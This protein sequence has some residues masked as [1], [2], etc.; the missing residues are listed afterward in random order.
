MVEKEDK[1]VL[2]REYIINLRNKVIYTPRYKRTPKA[3]KEL[4]KFVARHM[5]V[6]DNDLRKI[7]LDKYLN[8][9]LWFRGIQKPALKIKI[10]AKK[11]DSGK[12]LVELAELPEILKFKKLREEKIKEKAEKK[13][14]EKEEKKPEEETKQEE[15]AEEKPTEE[16]VEEKAKEKEK[17]KATVEAGLKEQDMKAKEMKHEIKV[18]RQPK[19][20]FRKALQK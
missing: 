16:K 19:H 8:E 7:K 18:S 11:F 2:E 17:E 15:K 20:Q 9:E 6:Y 4:K 12:V 14:E 13:E 3:I 5:K 10:K 1:I